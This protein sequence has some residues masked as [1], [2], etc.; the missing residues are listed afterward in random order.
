MLRD[1]TTLRLSGGNFTSST[2]LNF[3]DT[4]D[5]KSNK[6]IKG[7]LLYGRNGS[8]KSTIAKAFRKVSSE[9]VSGITFAS[10]CDNLGNLLHVSEDEKKHIYVFDEDYL[11]RNVK[12]Q[13]DHLDSIVMLGSAA[14]LTESIQDAETA[15]EEA[16]NK[17]KQQE[18]LFNEYNDFQNP[19]SLKYCLNAI[20]NALRGDDNWSG[21]DKEIN[22]GRHNT[23]VRDDTYKKFLS[24]TPTKSKSD[25]IVDYKDKIKILNDARTGKSI[26]GDIPSISKG[27]NLYDDIAINTLLQQKIEKP[28]LSE[29]EKHLLVLTQQG[30]TSELAD[31]L[32]FLKSKNSNECPYC[33]QPLTNERK[34][35]LIASIQKVL[36]RAVEEH[37]N[38]LRRHVYGDILPD[39]DRELAP[40]ADLQSYSRC[41]SLVQ[42]ISRAVQN[43]NELLEK[44]IENPFEPINA[45][46]TNVNDLVQQ[47]NESLE[48]LDKEK[49]EYNNTAKRARLMIEELTKINSEIAFYDIQKPVA[50]YKKQKIEYSLIE[51]KCNNLK[52]DYE[53]KART[54]EELEAQRR[55]IRLAI[56]SINACLTYIFFD[57]NR[58][59]LTYDNGYYKLF[60]HGKSVKPCDISV[61]ERNII[62]LS[63]F[64]TSIFEGKE[65]DEAYKE[66]Y[67]IV[68]DDPVSS[69]DTENRIGILS[70]LKYKISAFLEGNQYTKVLV[71]THDLMTFYDIHKILEEIVATCKKQG[72]KPDPKFNTFE[73]RDNILEPFQYKKRQE[74]SEILKEIYKYASGENSDDGLAIGNLMRQA[75]EAFA[76]FE[77]R[78][79]IEEVSNNPEII[80]I[81]PEEYRTYYQNLMY[82]LV[83]HGGSHRE[84]QVKAMK[85]F[86]FFSLVSDAEKKRTARDVLC[87]IYLLNKPHLLVHLSDD[88]NRA[89]VKAQLDSWCQDIKARAA[90]M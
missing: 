21:R 17:F 47:L 71:M 62:G 37:Q 74:Y 27:F 46:L 76:T 51:Q 83:L 78:T 31:R 53:K 1:F 13:Q 66:E 59:K 77:F 52:K 50:Q 58:L 8:G 30:K 42:K 4:T 54:V 80:T 57:D 41:Y 12:I 29:R 19:K 90:V 32:R 20:G 16:K 79:G 10:A 23:P 70:F 28:E 26:I 39:A 67:I 11:D 18:V 81:L 89:D 33:F 36:S 75:L 9:D 60:S 6:T 63:Y 86:R 84:E 56:D 25:L 64:F 15:R 2:S 68:I 5:G 73:L 72:Y 44:K 82:R 48:E 38:A 61:G 45:N 35:S 43:N 87:L 14:D 55:N 24:S 40:F 69:F 3:F 85:D 22:G 65:E 49:A 88:S 7:T 34:E